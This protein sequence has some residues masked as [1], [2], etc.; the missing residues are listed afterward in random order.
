M[1][2]GGKPPVGTSLYPDEKDPN[3]IVIRIGL[4]DRS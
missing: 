3:I 1:A 2:P 4:N